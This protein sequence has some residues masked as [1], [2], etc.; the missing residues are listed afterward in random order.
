MRPK[1]NSPMETTYTEFQPSLSEMN[2]SPGTRYVVNMTDSEA[3]GDTG[4][5]FR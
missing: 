1:H 4:H 3:L 5:S 2:E